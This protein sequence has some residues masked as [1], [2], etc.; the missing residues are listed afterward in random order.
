MKFLTK[1]AVLFYVILIM[2]LSSFVLLFVLNYIS[3]QYMINLSTLVY[4]DENLRMAF[5]T[6]LSASRAASDM[7]R[8]V[9]FLLRS[10]SSARGPPN[11]ATRRC[12]ATWT[13]WGRKPGIVGKFMS[14]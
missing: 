1:I 9:A 4:Y 13:G 14:L 8:E 2:F 6:R 7:S 12:S 3:I 5:A 10:A 11:A